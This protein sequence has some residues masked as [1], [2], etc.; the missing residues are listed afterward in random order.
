MSAR[1]VLLLGEIGV[2]KSSL[3]R[4]LVTGK[5]ETA[6]IPTIGVDVYSYDVPADAAGGPL[7][8]ILWDTDG[9]LGESVFG[10]VYS[11]QATAAV[12]VGDVTRRATLNTMV[13][14]GDGFTAAF[15]GRAA[16]FVVNKVDLLHEAETPELPAALSQPGVDL[17][18][19]S[20]LTGA[21][22]KDA[23]HRVAAT[24]LRRGQ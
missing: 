7:T 24:I 4:R 14:L 1:K 12:I 18:L 20:A 17:T 11:R 5:F 19:T 21:N 3:A 9:N 6:Y 10:H 13:S 8:L 16:S 22:V 15:P 23:F 2:G